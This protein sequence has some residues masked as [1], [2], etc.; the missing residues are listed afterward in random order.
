MQPPPAPP[1]PGSA[2]LWRGLRSGPGVRGGEGFGGRF[3]RAGVAL[4]KGAPETLRREPARAP[5]LRGFRRKCALVVCELPPGTPILA[6]G[7]RVRLSFLLRVHWALCFRRVA[8]AVEAV[9]RHLLLRTH[10][11][12]C[13]LSLPAGARGFAA[14]SPARFRIPSGNGWGWGCPTHTSVVKPL[15]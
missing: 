11:P 5:E 4:N 13:P 14:P 2:N 12:A 1:T 10:P 15:P 6:C 9:S 3:A 8:R 7:A